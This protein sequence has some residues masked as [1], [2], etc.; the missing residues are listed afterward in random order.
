[1]GRLGLG[2]KHHDIGVNHFGDVLL[3]SHAECSVLV[4]KEI[5][6]KVEL[7]RSRAFEFELMGVGE[8]FSDLLR[9]VGDNTQVIDIDSDVFI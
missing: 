3:G 4:A 8:Q 9:F 7:D 6:S 2:T 5:A 1:M